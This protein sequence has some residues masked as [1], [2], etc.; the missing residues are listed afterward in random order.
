MPFQAAA[1]LRTCLL[2]LPLLLHRLCSHMKTT[3]KSQHGIH[4]RC[5]AL[6]APERRVQAL[7][8]A[9]TLQ[10]KGVPSLACLAAEALRSHL[11]ET[12]NS[13]ALSCCGMSIAVV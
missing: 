12:I 2:L 9:E 10:A 5:C 13:G 8:P 6:A 4:V 1:P 7:F 3:C 11:I